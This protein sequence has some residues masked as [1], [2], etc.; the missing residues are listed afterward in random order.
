MLMAKVPSL[1]ELEEELWGLKHW[2][3]A[4]Q[5]KKRKVINECSIS[6]E[7]TSKGQSA[8]ECGLC[9]RRVGVGKGAPKR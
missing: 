8:C 9:A 3:A 1:V 2:G 7:G 5:Q 6:G 4:A